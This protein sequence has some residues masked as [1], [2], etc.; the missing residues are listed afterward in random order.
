MGIRRVPFDAA[1]EDPLVLGGS[2]TVTCFDCGR[3]GVV[4]LLCPL[5]WSLSTPLPV[6]PFPFVACGAPLAYDP[7]IAWPSAETLSR[8]VRTL[9]RG[10]VFFWFLEVSFE[11]V[12][13]MVRFTASPDV[14]IY[15]VG[16]VSLAQERLG[17]NRSI[18]LRRLHL[19]WLELC[20]EMQGE[21]Y[22]SALAS[23]PFA[24]DLQVVR[25][26]QTISLRRRVL[27]GVTFWCL[28]DVKGKVEVA[29]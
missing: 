24:D 27:V 17:D 5:D 21:P 22:A 14:Q 9:F 11:E 19:W 3:V 7:V 29:A 23:L 6:W 18:S 26:G 25:L 10:N 16:Y 4:L 2:T 15:S 1:V 28:Y 12:W 20:G 13:Y 8:C